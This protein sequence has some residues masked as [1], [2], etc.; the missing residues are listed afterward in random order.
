M[1]KPRTLNHEL[2]T[3]RLLLKYGD[4]WYRVCGKWK[5]ARVDRERE[6]RALEVD[7]QI[8]LF[9]VA[10]SKEKYL[11]VYTLL[12]LCHY[13]GMRPCESLHLRWRDINWKKRFL[14]IMRSKTPAGWRYPSLND[15]C[16]EALR[17]L[18]ERAVKLEIAKPEHYVFPYHP[19]GRWKHDTVPL[20]PTRP[21][22]RYQNQWDEIRKEA[23]LEGF[24]FYDGRH[25]AFTQMLEA[26]IPDGVIREQVGHVSPQVAKRYSH[27]RRQALN[28]AAAALEPA[29]LKNIL[30]IT[31][32]SDKDAT[33]Q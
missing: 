10:Q 13:C 30:L 29:H 4:V 24:W 6:G 22:T 33:V 9:S 2:S 12:V 28:Q 5:M 23:G 21:M 11:W 1:K 20:D 26:G 27:I 31:P 25:T 3:L 18:H 16:I 17:T 15:I 7:E 19:T 32:E 14:T 8:R